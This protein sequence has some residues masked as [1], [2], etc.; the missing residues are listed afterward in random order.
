MTNRSKTFIIQFREESGLDANPSQPEKLDKLIAANLFSLHKLSYTQQRRENK[1][2]KL[3]ILLLK[4]SGIV[5]ADRIKLLRGSTISENVISQ[6]T[7]AIHY[8][9]GPI[10]Y[11]PQ[12]LSSDLS[13]K[14]FM[15]IQRAY[16]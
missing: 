4:A 14:W 11:Y 16:I 5:V 13:V 3:S 10:L 8:S 2:Y 1:Y 7:A 9:M 15:H 12:N 6:L